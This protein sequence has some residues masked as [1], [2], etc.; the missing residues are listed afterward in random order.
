M[1]I[2]RLSIVRIIPMYARVVHLV[3]V[4]FEMVLTLTWCK[5]KLAINTLIFLCLQSRYIVW[6]VEVS[7]II[8]EINMKMSMMWLLEKKFLLVFNIVDSCLSCQSKISFVIVYLFMTS[9]KLVDAWNNVLPKPEIFRLI[10]KICLYVVLFLIS[11]TCSDSV[12]LG[13]IPK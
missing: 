8:E 6:V 7:E 4:S 13:N 3:L 10:G 11:G 9:F 12:E 5:T 2:I 1:T